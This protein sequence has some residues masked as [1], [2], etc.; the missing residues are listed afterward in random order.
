MLTPEELRAVMLR[1]PARAV[2]V[3]LLSLPP[4]RTA[5]QR[6][7]AMSRAA[8]PSAWVEAA[9]AVVTVSHGPCHP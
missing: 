9:Q 1:N 8:L 6:P 2:A 4:A 5:S 7:Q 3:M